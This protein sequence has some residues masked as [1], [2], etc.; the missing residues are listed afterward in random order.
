MPDPADPM[1]YPARMTTREVCELGRFGSTTLW[2]RMKA[3]TMPKP[4]DR[5]HESI[6]DR[7]AVL[8]ALG[9]GAPNDAI[10]SQAEAEPQWIVNDAV[11]ACAAGKRRKPKK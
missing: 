4:I 3:G 10:S 11:R 8:A 2:R 9:I 7:N 1:S 5:G 6:F